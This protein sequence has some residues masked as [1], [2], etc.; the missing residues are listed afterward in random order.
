[1]SN[2]PNTLVDDRHAILSIAIKPRDTIRYVLTTKN[3][4]YFIFVGVVGMFASNLLSFVGSEFTGKYTLGDIVYSTFMSSFLLYF[5]STLLSAGV[6]MLSAK[7]FGGVG[8][9]K[10]MFR[11][12]SMTM[13]PYIWIL[14]IVLF[15]M[16][17]APQSFFDIPYILP[18]MS[19]YIL[20]FI[21]GTLIIIAS[22][23]TYIITIVGISEVH[24]ISKWK[25]FFASLLVLILLVILA[26]A[27]LF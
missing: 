21:C 20:Q 13:V 11:M 25:A 8:K 14:P 22:I 2:L 6:L 4:P 7:V 24:K 26:Q 1:M 16:Q 15:W 12:I 3:L 17:F 5:L 23:W 19:D 27:V 18:G 9:F 10:E